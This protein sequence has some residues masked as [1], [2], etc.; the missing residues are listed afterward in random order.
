MRDRCQDVLVEP[1]VVERLVAITGGEQLGVRSETM[2]QVQTQR[3]RA[4][5]MRVQQIATYITSRRG[6]MIDILCFGLDMWRQSVMRA[7][8][9]SREEIG[10]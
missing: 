8:I 7:L 2:A 6:S 4:A 10:P 3:V 5:T 1:R 9:G